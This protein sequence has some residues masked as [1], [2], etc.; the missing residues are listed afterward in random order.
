[1]AAITSLST[2]DVRRAF[3]ENAVLYVEDPKIGELVKKM[4]QDGFPIESEGGLDFCEQN[5]FN[6]NVCARRNTNLGISN[7]L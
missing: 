7:V 1:M 6:D 3:T 4:Q 2:E 5:I